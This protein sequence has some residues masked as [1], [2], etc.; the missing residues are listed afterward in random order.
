MLHFCVCPKLTRYSCVCRSLEARLHI[1]PP[2]LW[3]LMAWVI[4][5]FSVLYGLLLR[6]GFCWIVGSSS[7]ILLFYSFLQSCYHVLPYHSIIP[8]VML[9]DQSLLALFWVC[10]LFFSQWL[11]MIIGLFITLLVGSCVPFISSWA[12]LA[13]LLSLGILYPFSAFPWAF[14]NSFGLP[15]PNYLIL[16]PWGS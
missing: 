7:F 3:L 15:W 11:N 14:T 9:F 6:A 5:W 10:C 4:F 8:A 2:T 13:H 1:L 16:H 12:S